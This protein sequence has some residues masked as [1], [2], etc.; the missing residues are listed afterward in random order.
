MPR[1][2]PKKS[3]DLALM[4]VNMA[5][6]PMRSAFEPTKL[7]CGPMKSRNKICE[8]EVIEL[9]SDESIEHD[10]INV[11]DNDE[12]NPYI[13]NGYSNK[14]V[15]ILSPQYAK[16]RRESNIKRWCQ[17]IEHWTLGIYETGGVIS[18]YDSIGVD[19]EDDE[20]IWVK[21][22]LRFVVKSLLNEENIE[23]AI[24]I[25][26]IVRQ[27]RNNNP[28]QWINK[29]FGGVNCGFHVALIAEGYLLRDGNRNILMVRGTENIKPLENK[30]L[31]ISQTTQFEEHKFSEAP[32][33]KKRRSAF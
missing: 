11:N 15:V 14:R 22:H 31:A 25:V 27:I 24:E 7:A 23:P 26:P 17:D 20:L 2:R 18:Y 3:P 19:D 29:Q 16:R 5:S 1:G 33:V 30:S 6:G 32:L 8:R 13:F 12:N 28:R 10:I 9:S 4:P 21:Q